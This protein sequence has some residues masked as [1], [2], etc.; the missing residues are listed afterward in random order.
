MGSELSE[1]HNLGY[2]MRQSKHNKI[3][4]LGEQREQY[5]KL[6]LAWC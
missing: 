1:Y 3:C 6:T 5:T 2:E 4:N